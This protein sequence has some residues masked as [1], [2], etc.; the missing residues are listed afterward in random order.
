MEYTMEEIIIM[1]ESE[2]LQI[3]QDIEDE[4]ET[5]KI[6]KYFMDQFER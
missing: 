3:I 6:D 1:D 4:I 5:G 2:A